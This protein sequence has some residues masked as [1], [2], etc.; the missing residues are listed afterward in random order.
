MWIGKKRSFAIIKNT[1]L[2]MLKNIWMY[3]DDLSVLIIWTLREI[4]EHFAFVCSCHVCDNKKKTQKN[5]K[6]FKHW[7]HVGK[8]DYVLCFFFVR[9]MRTVSIAYI[10]IIICNY[11]LF[12]KHITYF[13]RISHIHFINSIWKNISFIIILFCKR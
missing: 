9:G 6:H 10:L 11:I 7:Q 2:T 12:F 4:Q 5:M 8:R 13:T 1:Q 3:V